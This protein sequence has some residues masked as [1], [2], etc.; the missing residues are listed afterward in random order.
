LSIDALQTKTEASDTQLGERAQKTRAKLFQAAQDILSNEG[1]N[2]LN[3]NAVAKRAGV[4]PPTFYRHFPDKFALLWELSAKLL[5]NRDAVIMDRELAEI[6]TKNAFVEET[7]RILERTLAATVNF[8]AGVTLLHLL[9]ALPELQEIRLS[10]HRTMA[11][12]L[13]AEAFGGLKSEERSKLVLRA[14]LAIEIGYATIELLVEDGTQDEA[15]ILSRAAH[16][17]AELYD[18][19]LHLT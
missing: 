16:A 11:D 2:A 19:V 12:Y 7:R 9:R 6:T 1:Y 15:T 8:Q 5:A 18:D 10:S 3:T 17:I 14:R 13:V 4:T